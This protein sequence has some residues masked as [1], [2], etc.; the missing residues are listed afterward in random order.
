MFELFLTI[1]IFSTLIAAAWGMRQVRR[2]RI[3]GRS[4]GHEVEVATDGIGLM[5][6]VFIFC[7]LLFVLPLSIRLLFTTTISGNVSPNLFDFIDYFPFAVLLNTAFLV[8]LVKMCNYQTRKSL[9]SLRTKIKINILGRV[10]TLTL[11][12]LMFAISFLLVDVLAKNFGGFGSFV[13]QGYRITESFIDNGVYAMGLV[14]IQVLSVFLFAYFGVR[15]RSRVK[16]FTV[17]VLALELVLLII[18]GR[19][20][21]VVFLGVSSLIVWH[22]VYRKITRKWL[23]VIVMAGFFSMNL[24]GMIRGEAYS[25]F[26]EAIN[27]LSENTSAR[28]ADSGMETYIYTVTE[29]QFV[30]PFATLPELMAHL[31]NDMS[32]HYG[33]ASLGSFA[34]I[35]PTIIWPDRP[36]PLSN[37][38][39][40]TFYNSAAKSNEGRQFFVLTAPYMDFG[41]FGVLFFGLLCGWLFAKWG[42]F[43]MRRIESPIFL[44]MYAVFVG[45]MLSFV[46]GDM[47]GSAVVFIKAI[48]PLL[49]L[50]C[51]VLLTGSGVNRYY[52]RS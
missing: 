5:L 4:N 7:D 11:V 8:L 43:L 25:S 35:I 45:S 29:G 51:F 38:Y 20:A 3:W 13:L 2:L 37:W 24:V 42:M 16:L 10:P 21:E 27:V 22:F 23:F 31:G 48:V 49:V 50:L 12:I 39:E 52:G 6:L 44:T 26:S 18:M 28:S 9:A 15:G 36:L 40:R 1:S 14:W 32:Y 19:R 33:G 47:I 30:V 17:G 41:V 34:L 46:S